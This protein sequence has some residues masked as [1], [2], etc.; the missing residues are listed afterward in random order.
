M[1][2]TPSHSTTAMQNAECGS[3]PLKRGILPAD[4]ESEGVSVHSLI[5]GSSSYDID[6][7]SQ[8]V[9]QS[10]DPFL[11]NT[12]GEDKNVNFSSSSE[13]PSLPEVEQEEKD[14]DRLVSETEIA[15]SELTESY[16][17]VAETVKRK[18]NFCKSQKPVLECKHD[19]Q[20]PKRGKKPKNCRQGN[21][22]HRGKTK[23]KSCATICQEEKKVDFPD[24]LVK[25]HQNT[26]AYLNPSLSKYEV[27]LCVAHQATETQLS[28]QQMVSFLLLCFDEINHLL[29]EIAKDGEDLLQQVDGNLSWPADKGNPKEQPDLLQ[30][31]LQYTVNKMQ[32]LNGTVA[33]LTSEVLQESCSFL[34]S[35]GSSLEEKLRAKQGFDER[36]LRTIKL[37]EASIVGSYHPHPDDRTLYSEDS[38]IGI[39]GES[40]KDLNFLD[41]QEVHASC[42]SDSLHL[43]LNEATRNRT[44]C[45]DTALQYPNTGIRIPLNSMHSAIIHED[46]CEECES[47]EASSTSEDND[48]NSLFE[49]ES[50]SLLGKEVLPKK[51]TTVPAS[52]DVKLRRS[53]K[54]MESPEKEKII[55]KMKDAI[56]EKIKFVP[57][58]TEKREWTEDENGRTSQVQRPST[59]SRSQ[60]AKVKQRRSRSAESLKN[61]AEDPTLLELQRTQKVLNKKLEKFH[62]HNEN[63]ET[64]CKSVSMNQKEQSKLQDYEHVSHR[65]AT[66]KLK[67][68][69]AKNFSILPSQDKVPLVR[70]DQNAT[71]KKGKKC[72]KPVTATM[73]SQEQTSSKENEPPGIQKANNA[74]CTPPRKSVK[75]LIETFSPA[76]GL[77]KPI[78]LR[79]LGPMK[80]IQKFGLPSITSNL[81]LPRGLIPL[82]QK[83]RISPIGDLNC[84]MNPTQCAFDPVVE[85]VLLSG[86][87]TNEEIGEDI[88]ENLPPPPPEMLA[89]LSSDSTESAEG[90]RTEN[91]CSEIANKPPKMTEHCT[92]KKISQISQR[93]KASLFFIDLLPSKNLNSP[94]YIANNISKSTVDSKPRKCS[95]E[96]NSIHMAETPLASHEDYEM[97]EA[98]DLYRQNHKIIPLQ[99]P[100]EIPEQNKRDPGNKELKAP[101]A[102]DPKQSSSDS[103]GKGEKTTGFVRRVS[104]ARTPPSSLPS[105]KMLPSPPLHHRHIHPA[106]S[107]VVHRQLSPPASS[108]TQRKMPSPPSQQKLPS[109]PMG[110]KQHSPPTHRKVLSPPS[111][112]REPSP[113]P[114]STPSPPDSPSRLL[115]GLQNNLDSGDEQQ[116]ASP[117]IVSNVRS[118]FCPATS[119]LFEAKPLLSPSSSTTDAILRGHPEISMQ[120]NNTDPKQ[121]GEQQKRMGLSVTRPQSFIRRSFSDHRP[122]FSLPLPLFTSTSSEPVLNQASMEEK[123]KKEGDPWSSTCF[124]E[125]K[126]T[127]SSSYLDLY[128]VGQGLQ[129]DFGSWKD[130]GP[131]D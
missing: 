120:R 40:V 55:L 116:P 71:S 123:P 119:S 84:P 118:I 127:G 50:D 72:G 42:D 94:N 34:Q 88:I 110:R 73:F 93:M 114:F 47:T 105:E 126:R 9:T 69:L 27:I 96:L 117:K 33:S 87:D 45:V 86:N 43:S 21:Q 100:K 54:R 78:S 70:Q 77:V 107:P 20:T 29:E 12:S 6:D 103:V 129:K 11:K 37:L 79:T 46:E 15:V 95:L 16:R 89:G 62:M 97:K 128:I 1:G 57:A 38:G 14:T 64:K 53:T 121:Y 49:A 104:P 23:D 22:D 75:K 112:R 44:G 31:L 113:P 19:K 63:K 130:G 13:D 98:A 92:T 115:K 90:A 52:K 32:L 24:L 18:Q 81:P 5:K 91:S 28:L 10:K 65:S 76:E 80:C 17:Y 131:K 106:F 59:A 101:L 4:L 60:K 26:Y 48:D 85:P 7:F 74:S 83:H 30:Q 61:Q 99:H 3:R 68:S 8:G 122:G 124:S 36:L 111:H 58:K 41:K 82:N 35:A 109:P 108:P 25:A 125:V 51:P 66:N 2:C 102:L 67:A 39:D 56:S